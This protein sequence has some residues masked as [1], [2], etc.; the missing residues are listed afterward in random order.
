MIESIYPLTTENKKE[1]TRTPRQ[2]QRKK[3]RGTRY[4]E[5]AQQATR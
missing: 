4:A 5:S 3:R 1:N 2:I